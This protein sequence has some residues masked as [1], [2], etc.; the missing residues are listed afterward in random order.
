MPTLKE[1]IEIAWN[2]LQKSIEHGTIAISSE[3]TFV[4]NFAMELAKNYKCEGIYLDFEYQAYDNIDGSDKYLD[5]L[6]YETTSPNIKYAIE[7]KAPMKSGSGNSNQT[8]TR[9]KIYKDIARLQYLTENDDE[10]I[11]GYFFMI[12]NEAPY[13]NASEHRDNTFDT[14]HQHTGSTNDFKKQYGLQC[15]FTFTFIWHNDH[16]GLENNHSFACLKPIFIC[17]IKR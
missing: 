6:V 14:S 15:D 17:K 8:E 2:N 13:F 9:K 4:F 7:F 11:G 5:L 12:T 1:Q 10:I 16:L 3:K